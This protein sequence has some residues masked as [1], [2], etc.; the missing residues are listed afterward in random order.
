MIVNYLVLKTST[1]QV[2]NFAQ[3]CAY[4]EKIDLRTSLTED[5]SL[6]ELDGYI[7]L[8]EFQRKFGVQLSNAAYSYVRPPELQ[9]GFGHRLIYNLILVL[10]IPFLFIYP[11]LPERGETVEQKI[12]RNFNRLT[13]GDLAA[14]LAVGYFVKRELINIELPR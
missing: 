3:Q 13:L 12:K 8:D 7:F 2:L 1:T 10:A 9:G 5:L 4:D 14:S 6:W 11:F